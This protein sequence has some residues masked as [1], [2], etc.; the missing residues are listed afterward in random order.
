MERKGGDLLLTH[1]LIRSFFRK[2]LKFY[3][4]KKQA[5]WRTIPHER[6]GIHE[7]HHRR[8]MVAIRDHGPAVVQLVAGSPPPGG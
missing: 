1:R 3:F 5:P 7:L 4:K 8:A 2:K 6:V